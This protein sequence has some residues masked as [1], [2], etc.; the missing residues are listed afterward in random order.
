VVHRNVKPGN[1]LIGPD[2]HALLTDFGI[3]KIYEDTLELT[4]EGQLVGTP[5]YM[6]PEQLQAQA[7]DART[8]MYA[9]GVALYQVLTGELPFVA[10]TPLAVA[11]MHLHSSMRPPRQRQ[12]PRRAA[13]LPRS[14]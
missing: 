1:I 8:D 12:R 11:L 5:A 7:V 9:L 10:E 3:A 2:G 4:G 6:A 13:S 14:G